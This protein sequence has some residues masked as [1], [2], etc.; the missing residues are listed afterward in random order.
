[1]IG[2]LLLQSAALWAQTS[3]TAATNQDRASVTRTEANGASVAQASTGP[4]EVSQVRI[5]RL[6]QV[7]GS[8][9]VDRNT[10]HGFEGAFANIPMVQGAKLRTG[11]GVAEVE[12]ED[13]SS[14][15]LAPNSEVTFEELGRDRTGGTL[16]RVNVSRGTTYVSLGKSKGNLFAM[17]DG[18]ESILLADGSHVRLDANETKAELAVFEGQAQ[19]ASAGGPSSTVIQKQTVAFDPGGQTTATVDRKVEERQLDAWDQTQ[20]KY[21]QQKAGFT[22]G[23]NGLYGTNDLNYYGQFADMPGCGSMW[24][25]YFA[26]AAWDPFANGIWAYYPTAGYSW[27]SPYPWGWLPFHSGSWEQC[28]AGGWGWRPGGQFYGLANQPVVKRVKAPLLPPRS[29]E[30]AAMVPVNSRPL[31]LSGV[32]TQNSFVFRKDSAGLGVPREMTGGLRGASASAAQRGDV[33]TGYE[34]S[35][36]TGAANVSS[37]QSRTDRVA[38]PVYSPPSS[39]A[40][41]S[42]MSSASSYSSASASSYS[43][44]GASAA[45]SAGASAG[46]HK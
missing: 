33:S 40:R 19:L 17:T 14:L 34:A 22:G 18:Q 8:V 4:V 3:E 15:R 13:N 10:G 28:G 2:L 20:Q 16:T 38:S 7:R 5:V 45:S 44:G 42:S 6:S 36:W 9:Q 25:P 31:T 41:T 32:D 43:G 35:S 21:H 26:S 11:T 39:G 24:R 27:V 37:L 46:G 1:M 23:G 12:F 29:P 30:R